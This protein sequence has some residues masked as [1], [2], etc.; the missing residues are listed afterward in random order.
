[1]NGQNKNHK[2]KLM[3]IYD[4]FGHFS[5]F[6]KVGSLYR[7]LQ[8]YDEYSKYF[9][10]VFIKTHETKKFKKLPENVEHIPFINVPFRRFFYFFCS[11]FFNYRSVNYVE[12]VGV[13]G[14]F[15]A[16]IYKFVGAKIFFYHRWGL[17]KNLKENKRPFLAFLA[18]IIQILAFKIADVIAVPTKRLWD[19][20]RKHARNVYILPNYV[21][22]S[23]FN[24]VVMKKIP[25]LL[26]YVGRLHQEKNIYPLLKVMKQLP[27]YK[28]WIIGHGPLRNKLIFFKS[29]NGIKNVEFLGVIPHEKLPNY[30]NKAEAFIIVSHSEGHPKAL[31]EAMACELPCIGSNVSGIRDV[32]IDG[33]TGVLCERNVEDIKRRILKL[34]ADRA[35][36]REI[37]RNARKFTI[38]N[39]SMD[40][41]IERRIKLIKGELDGIEPLYKEV[42]PL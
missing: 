41:I 18:N 10:K 9:E 2:P 37:G 4:L 5:G 8:P 36:M 16:L 40:K 22:T 12:V 7:I 35:K 1:M 32:I 24:R 14:I 30:L 11:G 6:E 38:E 15:P 29:K 23:H 33:E 34:F 13:T 42:P 31:I 19:E 20:V 28:L 26:I 3:V 27:Q 21:D 17:A 39:Y 25:N